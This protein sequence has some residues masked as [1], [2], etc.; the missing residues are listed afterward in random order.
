[1]RGGYARLLGHAFRL[2]IMV[3]RGVLAN[4]E[5]TTWHLGWR[6]CRHMTG[7]AQLSLP[8]GGRMACWYGGSVACSPGQQAQVS[9]QGSCSQPVHGG[10]RLQQ[11]QVKC[12]C[13]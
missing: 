3:L 6:W 5:A 10:A 4:T 11:E 2:N 12:T 1:M 9:I 8:A 13:S 7:G